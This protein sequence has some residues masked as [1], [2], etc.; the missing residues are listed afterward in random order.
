MMM[1]AEMSTEV[2]M[3]V[4]ADSSARL[5]LPTSN[6][7]AMESTSNSAEG[8]TEGPMEEPQLIPVD[9]DD[10]VIEVAPAQSPMIH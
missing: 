6:V 4:P 1:P 3:E 9:C 2:P 10:D 8:P 7:E 5:E